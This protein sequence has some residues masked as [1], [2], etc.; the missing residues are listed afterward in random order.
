VIRTPEEERLWREVHKFVE[1]IPSTPEPNL[2]RLDE[3]K[4]EIKKKTYLTPEMIDE[5]AA[6]LTI[7]FMR[8]E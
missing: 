1:M 7:R 8:R 3:I 4:E 6:R 2:G 5:T